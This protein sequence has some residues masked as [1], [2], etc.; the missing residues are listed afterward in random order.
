MAGGLGLAVLG[1]LLCIH[2]FI[3]PLQA[4]WTQ[5][6][7]VT[8]TSFKFGFDYLI[9]PVQPI[10]LTP[11][12]VAT[13]I[14]AGLFLALASYIFGMFLGRI[15]LDSYERGI[16]SFDRLKATLPLLGPYVLVCLLINLVIILGCILLIIPGIIFFMKY[17]F[18][19][20]VVL[21]SDLGPIEAMKRSGEIMYG[22]KWRFF[23]FYLLCFLLTAV[24]SIIPIFGPMVMY[25]VIA[26]ARTYVYRTLVEVERRDREQYV[27]VPPVM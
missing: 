15:G 27:P 2:Q 14:V 1:V 4:T 19:D 10:V 26:F 3:M 16:S 25:F 13:L 17:G 24:S 23:G 12:G 22:H 7:E 6:A 8:S 21:D 9:T 20:L 18:G 11:A 5:G